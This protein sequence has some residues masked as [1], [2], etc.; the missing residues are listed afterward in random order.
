M[1]QV[2]IGLVWS[3]KIETVAM[4]MISHM[5]VELTET[6]DFFENLIGRTSMFKEFS[7]AVNCTRAGP[8]VFM[9][10]VPTRIRF[11]TPDAAAIA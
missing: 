10:K 7:Y 6:T 9:Y 3:K 5:E 8:R 2:F 1:S 4:S 11:R